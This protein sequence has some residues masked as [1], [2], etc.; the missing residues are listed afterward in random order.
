M[1]PPAFLD[2]QEVLEI[3]RDQI[4]RYGG[5][6]GVR[7]MGSLESALAVPRSGGFGRY[8]HGDLF[9]MAAAYLYHIVL[10][11]PFVDGNKRVGTA[12]ALVFL[13]MNGVRVRMANESLVDL[14]TDVARG[15]TSK[16]GIA[17]TLRRHAR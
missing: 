13:F 7:D 14:V 12:A 17:E 15:E 8:F 1:R 11:H 5:S 9:E 10:N 16:S 2:L 6:P 4:S 3:H